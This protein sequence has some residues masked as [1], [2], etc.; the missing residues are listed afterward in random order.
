[1]TSFYKQISFKSNP[2]LIAPDKFRQGYGSLDQPKP[3]IQKSL[4][5][6][7]D[8][9]ER[10]RTDL[11]K[12]FV[13]IAGSITT[14]LLEEK[15]IGKTVSFDSIHEDYI[16]HGNKTLSKAAVHALSYAAKDLLNFFDYLIEHSAKL[17]TEKKV[18]LS[19]GIEHGDYEISRQKD[20]GEVC[21]KLKIKGTMIGDSQTLKVVF[22]AASKKITEIQLAKKSGEEKE[23]FIIRLNGNT[24]TSFKTKKWNDDEGSH[25]ITNVPLANV[26]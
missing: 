26:A 11:A 4:H 10:K 19:D 20:K 24:R 2:G 9:K 16:S 6:I 3:E 12:F 25:V 5:F 18:K 13:P 14:R 17:D 8:D 22:Q 15:S 7:A 23:A 21:L 1:M